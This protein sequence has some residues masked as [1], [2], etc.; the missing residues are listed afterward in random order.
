MH[1]KPVNKSLTLR[2][3]KIQEKGKVN[4][5]INKIGKKKK[6]DYSQGEDVGFYRIMDYTDY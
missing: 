1:S 6:L 3:D 5:R 2:Y 4:S